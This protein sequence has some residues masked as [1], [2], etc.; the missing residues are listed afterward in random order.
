MKR[1]HNFYT[2]LAFNLAE[3]NLGKTGDNPSVGCIVVK[4]NSVIS[5]GETS[6]KGRPHAEFNALN[7]KLNFRDSDIYT[8]LEPC[9]HYG[10]TPPCTNIII[11][12]KIKNL[13]FCFNDP[14]K[15]TYR[16][17]IKI[18]N[19]S[20][21]R[22][23]QISL[24]KNNFY[25]S[26]FLNKK[27]KFPYIDAKI[28]ISRDNY[29]INKNSKWITNIR[30][31]K[32][33]HLL[34]S[35]YDCILSTSSTI[36]KDNSLLNCRI[37]GL[38]KP[39]SDLI[40]IDRNLKL[41]KKLK[42]F[43]LINQRKTY[44]FTSSKNKKKISYFKK[45]KIK[46]IQFDYLY[47]KNDFENL[48]KTIFLL[49]KRRIFIEAGVIFLNKL[50]DFELINNLFIFKSNIILK[51]RGIGKFKSPKKIRKSNLVNVNLDNDNLYKVRIR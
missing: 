27:K 36:N 48:F 34:R 18:L 43:D 4:K 32:V 38:N 29:T 20:N 30:S 10:L 42:L 7:K 26:Y 5:S 41:K 47:K 8:T 50:I 15:R 6:V 1:N 28:A 16:K 40:I 23:K 24:K 39:Q 9:T 33:T 22:V 11:K 37:E 46:I 25:E 12:K 14:D 13:F 35:R 21:V 51:Q 31:R 44:I 45:M 19:K 17:S 49:G 2:N 3:K